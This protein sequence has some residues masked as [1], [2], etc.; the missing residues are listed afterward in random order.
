YWERT[1]LTPPD[2]WALERDV[3]LAKELGFNGVRKHQKLED[4]RFYAWADHLGLLVWA[5]LPSAYAFDPVA[6]ERL[7]R[8][9]MEAIKVASPHPSVVAWVPF[10]ESW[11]VPDLP[12]SAAQRALVRGLA[13]LTRALDP[14]RPVVGNDGWEMLAT[15]LVNVHDYERDPEALARRYATP[16]AVGTALRTHRPGGKIGRAS[17]RGRA[18]ITKRAVEPR[19]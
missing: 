1:H 9:W 17:C 2:T 15:D 11:G 8:T 14:T 4:P 12:T 19:I 18:W 16:E 13:D 7:T 6:A 5:E 3:R 10:N